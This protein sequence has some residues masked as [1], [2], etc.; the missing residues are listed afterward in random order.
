MTSKETIQTLLELLKKEILSSEET[1]AVKEAIGVLS[2]VSLS[3]SGLKR[4]GE[5]R[6]EKRQNDMN[7]ES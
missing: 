3:E 2:W 4:M 5:K 6:K 1:N 7:N